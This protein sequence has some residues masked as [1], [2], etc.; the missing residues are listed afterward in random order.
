[1]GRA[2]TPWLERSLV[3]SPRCVVLVQKNEE[4]WVEPV[5]PK[6]IINGSWTSR[7]KTH[8]LNTATKYYLSS[9]PARVSADENTTNSHKRG[10]TSTEQI[11]LH[12]MLPANE[13]HNHDWFRRRMVPNFFTTK[14][15]RTQSLDLVV[16]PCK[17]T[18]HAH[19]MI[20]SLL[21][22]KSL[23]NSRTR[24]QLWRQL[25]H[26]GIYH[27]WWAHSWYNWWTCQA[28]RTVGVSCRT[29]SLSYCTNTTCQ[30]NP[31]SVW[32]REART[33][34]SSFSGWMD[35]AISFLIKFAR[36]WWMQGH[37]RLPMSG[38]FPAQLCIARDV[39][40][41]DIKKVRYI[42]FR[43]VCMFKVVILSLKR[44]YSSTGSTG[45]SRTP[46]QSPWTQNS[47]WPSCWKPLLQPGVNSISQRLRCSR[48][49][50]CTFS[51]S[52]LLWMWDGSTGNN[53][54]PPCPVVSS[55]I[56]QSKN[57]CDFS[58]PSSLPYPHIRIK[59][60]G[61]WVL[62]NTVTA[63]R[64][65]WHHPPKVSVHFISV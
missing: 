32:V 47:A 33:F 8:A 28:N 34:F 35:V 43:L 24:I 56:P 7:T 48:C 4:M 65:L 27:L 29:Y 25:G 59:G 57:S 6:P 39:C 42:D 13:P 55:N 23:H 17:P 36:T 31:L 49:Q 53:S 26:C 64:Q 46:P 44:P 1:M 37:P 15:S 3:D 19:K 2:M 60:I 30:D 40:W 58:A 21:A 10:M 50:R 63:V 9:C 54:T 5:G 14:S 16:S 41:W 20:A 22:Y 11:T 62:A 18:I 52:R 38:L 61:L 51:R 12:R 45:T